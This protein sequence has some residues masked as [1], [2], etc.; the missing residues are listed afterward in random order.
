M[1]QELNQRQIALTSKTNIGMMLI[2]EIEGFDVIFGSDKIKKFWRIG[3]KGVY[4]GRPDL[5]IGGT[6]DDENALPLIDMEKGETTKTISQQ[7]ELDKGG[8]G[9]IQSMKISLVDQAEQVTKMM[10]PGQYVDDILGREATVYLGFYGGSHPEDSFRIFQGIVDGVRLA[11][12]HVTINVSHPT[13]LENKKLFVKKQTKLTSTISDIETFIPVEDVTGFYNP[14]NRSGVQLV[15]Y[16]K[17]EDEIIKYTLK[18]SVGSA[19]EFRGC[20]RGQFG[21]IPV[22]H[23]IDSDVES[24]YYLK[25]DATNL[26][27]ALLISDGSMLFNPFAQIKADSLV[28]ISSTQALKNAIF[29]QGNNV[30]ESYGLVVGD[31][32]SVT[33]AEN[34][35]NNFGD[36]GPSPQRQITS[37]GENETGYYFIV[38]GPP[39]TAEVS[40]NIQVSIVSQFN[41]LPEGCGLSSRMVDIQQFFDVKKLI[42]TSLAYYEF[43]ITEEIEAKDFLNMEVFMPSGLYQVPRKG[44]VSIDSNLPAI[45]GRDSKVL[46]DQNVLNPEK[47]VIERTINRDFYNAVIWKYDFD[48]ID[49]KFKQVEV[50]V[51]ASSS[52]KDKY[53]DKPLVIE[54]KGLRRSGASLS[55]VKRQAAYILNRYKNAAERLDV[56]VN[57]K[58]GF[59]IDISDIVTLDG[60]SLKL[61][62]SRS[63]KRDFVPRKMQVINKT[64]AFKSEIKLSLLDTTFRN[65]A[66]YGT[67]APASKILA[68]SES[69]KLILSGLYFDSNDSEKNKWSGLYIGQRLMVRSYDWSQQAETKIIAFDDV[70]TRL[71]Y[72]ENLPFTPTEG[73]ILEIPNYD[74]TN[75]REMELAKDRHC[76]LNP[77][78]KVVSSVSSKI[79][80]V[81]SSD[82]ARV[83]PGANVFIRSMDFSDQIETTVKNI[84][85]NE[86][87]V[88][89]EI[90]FAIDNTYRVDLVGFLDGGAPYRIL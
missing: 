41:F 43:P 65:D 7:L 49:E 48:P 66:R 56:L 87:E 6:I 44:R 79:F 18:Y 53:G 89:D 73:M 57:L 82:A 33:G 28:N 14:L 78:L 63:G 51:D 4:I 71:A 27:L 58:T 5:Y 68:G 59:N 15:S 20:E 22:E 50:I 8:S 64:F 16:I 90:P 47:L 61:A 80:E 36:E 60:R 11:Q 54:S 39:L 25:G 37:F 23:E 29:F 17:I 19:I 21:T 24:F 70:N 76:F 26:A 10:S 69:D 38:D 84:S 31:W 2:V 62:D 86:I 1:A 88:N 52:I 72:V 40:S 77:T 55:L 3:D 85:G 42:G 46:N 9:S 32:V 12:S 74:N 81:S 30:K 45:A 83:L 34:F 75:K 35:I 13:K 67:I